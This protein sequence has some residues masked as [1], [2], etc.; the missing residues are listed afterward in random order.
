MD[1]TKRN[2]YETQEEVLQ[3]ELAQLKAAIRELSNNPELLHMVGP[4]TDEQEAAERR[5]KRLDDIDAA[6]EWGSMTPSASADRARREWGEIME[7][8][9]AFER[10]YC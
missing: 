10:R 3:R 9:G 5:M 4:S 2:W 8:Q 1:A 7:V 6:C